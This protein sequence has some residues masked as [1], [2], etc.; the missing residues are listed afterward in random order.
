MLTTIKS[1]I[2]QKININALYT[3]LILEHSYNNIANLII[4]DNI[5][6]TSQSR[7]N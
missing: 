5:V 2:L 1:G 6:M 4:V 3:I 7:L